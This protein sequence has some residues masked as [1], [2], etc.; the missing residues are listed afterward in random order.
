[1]TDVRE[2][3]EHAREVFQEKVTEQARHM[4]WVIAVTCA[5]VRSHVTCP[6][7]SMSRVLRSHVT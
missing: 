4:S 6:W 5:K 1:M 7:S 2:E 3:L